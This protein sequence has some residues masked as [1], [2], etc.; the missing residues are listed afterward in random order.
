MLR[1]SWKC[2]NA[3]PFECGEIIILSN[4]CV[5]NQKSNISVLEDEKDYVCLLGGLAFY[6]KNCCHCAE[7][8]QAVLQCSGQF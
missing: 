6:S 5:G 7:T 2:W 8:E 1:G 4:V 3:K